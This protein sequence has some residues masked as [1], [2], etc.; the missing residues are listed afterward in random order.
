MSQESKG[1]GVPMKIQDIQ[2]LMEMLDKSGLEELELETGG[3]KIRLLKHRDS[4]VQAPSQPQVYMMGPSMAAP[5]HLAPQAAPSSPAAVPVSPSPSPAQEAAPQPASVK[6]AT[7]AEIKSP[8]VGTFY[9]APAPGADPF[10]KVGD[11]VRKG[12]TLCII[13]AM[14]LMNEIENEVDGTVVEILPENAQP[15][16][17]GEVLF[18]VEPAG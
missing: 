3:M 1:K 7:A 2:K 17:Y 10:V 15:V 18:H 11:K 14:K 9:R 16:E 5:P 4:P 6:S 12:Q 8:M 13:E